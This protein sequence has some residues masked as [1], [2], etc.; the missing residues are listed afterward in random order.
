MEH[1]SETPRL[2][3]TVSDP[4]KQ[5][6]SINQYVSYKVNTKTDLPDFDHSHSSV[7]RRYSDFLWLFTEL[8]TLYAG[9]IIPPLPEKHVIGK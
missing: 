7:V 3:I 8:Q 9:V 4:V 2:E 1:D 6:E 5:G